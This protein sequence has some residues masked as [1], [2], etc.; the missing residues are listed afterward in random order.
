M[1]NF[2]ITG[3]EMHDFAKKI[4]SYN[5]SLTGVGQRQT[6]STIKE[7]IPQTK[8][9]KYRSGKRVFDWKIPDEWHVNYAY[10]T[11]PNGEKIC[12]YLENNL[13]L[14]G[15]SE[16]IE[17]DLSLDELQPFLHSIPGQ[18]DAIPYVTSYYEKRWGV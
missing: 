5:R 8:I 2:E 6:L 13:H 1:E 4:W 16:A 3:T 10:I 18:P 17:Q 9:K 11:D 14:I 15:Y 7:Q 12:D